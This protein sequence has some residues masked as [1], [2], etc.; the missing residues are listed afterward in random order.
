MLNLIRKIN[1]K[2]KY[3]FSKKYKRIYDN[4]NRRIL[5]EFK[6]KVHSGP[7]KGMSYIDSSNGSTFVPKILGSYEKELHTIVEKIIE[8]EYTNY[9]DIGCA[10]GY[11]A[12]G[13]AYRLRSNQNVKIFA[14]DTN[15]NA[16]HNLNK[17]ARLNGIENKIVSKPLFDYQEFEHFKGEGTF[18]MCD[19]EGDELNLI[20]VVLAPEFLNCDLLVEVHDGG[21][22]RK[23]IKEHLKRSFEKTHN[24]QIIDFR[25]KG[26]EDYNYIKWIPSKS[27]RIELLDEK[28]KYGL[29]WMLITIKQ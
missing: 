16:L 10:E 11:Y 14:Y 27:K 29:E 23:E 3:F 22:R 12:V 21:V 19:I 7:F 6:S 5:L 1:F 20:N 9:V 13:F 8:S 25:A 4:L 24:I 28:R 2:L 26:L 18:I 17:M 15:E